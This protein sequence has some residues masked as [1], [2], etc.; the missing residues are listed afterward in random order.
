MMKRGLIIC[1][2]LTRLDAT[3]ASIAQ[4]APTP[5]DTWDCPPRCDL[6]GID[7]SG[8]LHNWVIFGTIQVAVAAIIF[9]ARPGYAPE[10]GA[11]IMSYGP[12][13]R[14]TAET[15]RRCGKRYR[16]TS[17]AVGNLICQSQ[18]MLWTILACSGYVQLGGSLDDLAESH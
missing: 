13:Y 10:Q 17:I 2:R 18:V 4:P 7:I 14:L 11:F 8:T 1:L 16:E 12:Y 5:S 6:T 3:Y 9:T 15:C